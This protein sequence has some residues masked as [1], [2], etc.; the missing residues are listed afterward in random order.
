MARP[1]NA[2]AELTKRRILDSAIARFG[3]QGL[4]ATSLRVI[5][6]DVG[7]TFATV[8]HYFGSKSELFSCCMEAGYERLAELRDV[9]P[10]TLAATEGGTEAKVAA[11]A[12]TAFAYARDHAVVSRF[13]LRATLYETSASER[14]QRSQ[15]Q[16]LDTVSEMLAP[17]LSRPAQELRV[18]LQGLMFLVTRLAVMSADELSIVAGGGRRERTDEQ[19]ADYVATVAVGTLVEKN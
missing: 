12:R 13:L 14:T 3:G 7:I 15:A 18:P 4:K 19:L 6:G 2:D 8:H 16:Y 5:A 17:V 10:R 11:V 1:R 9:L